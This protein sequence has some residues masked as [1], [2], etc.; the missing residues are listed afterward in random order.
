MLDAFKNE[1]RTSIEE[2]FDRFV[3]GGIDIKFD[4]DAG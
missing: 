3:S 2:V 4:R 1:Y